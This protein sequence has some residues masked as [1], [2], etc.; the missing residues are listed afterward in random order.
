MQDLNSNR[1]NNSRLAWVV[2]ARGH[3]G[4][5][6]EPPPSPPSSI[7]SSISNVPIPED[8]TLTKTWHFQNSRPPYCSLRL[9]TRCTITFV[10]TSQFV[11]PVALCNKIAV[12]LCNTT[13]MHCG[14]CMK[15][16]RGFLVP[17]VTGVSSRQQE[18]LLV[19]LRGRIG[20]VMMVSSERW[21]DGWFIQSTLAN[22]N[23]QRTQWYI[24]YFS[25]L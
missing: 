2:H 7:P 17:C 13:L 18:C 19:W 4:E 16:P 25:K 14:H 6:L 12:A 1:L 21:K 3:A 11:I 23:T 8:E 9:L 24:F 15:I 10:I 5:G 22:R 20:A